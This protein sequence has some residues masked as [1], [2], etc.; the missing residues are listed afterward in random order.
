MIPSAIVK[1]WKSLDRMT[2]T[3]TAIAI[4]GL[5]VLAAGWALR[6]AFVALVGAVLWTPAF[7]VL[8]ADQLSRGVGR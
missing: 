4:V 8:A 3:T 7:S 1:A 6:S 2:R 5:V